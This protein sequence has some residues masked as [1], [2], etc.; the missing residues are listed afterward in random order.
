MPDALINHSFWSF[1]V[2][3]YT[4]EKE[5]ILLGLQDDHGL[6]C[7]WLLFCV[8]LSQKNKV[9]PLPES[10]PV[11][12]CIKD[13]SKQV[14]EPIRYLRQ[15]LKEPVE[16]CAITQGYKFRQQIKH[17]ELWAEN[18]YMYW[19]YCSAD[20][21]LNSTDSKQLVRINTNCYINYYTELTTINRKLKKELE[22]WLRLAH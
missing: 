10:N 16:K 11:Y 17:L 1:A 7:C 20:F 22:Q 4:P 9:L 12:Q 13:W 8:W 21:Y 6:D 15:R 14:I 19:L 18:R 3:Y 5:K 2:A